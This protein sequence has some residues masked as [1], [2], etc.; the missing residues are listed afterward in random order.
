MARSIQAD[1]IRKHPLMAWVVTQDQ[2]AHSGQFVARLVTN[3]PTVYVMLAGTLAEL[4]D[5]LPPRLER[6]DRHSFHPRE[7]VEIWFVPNR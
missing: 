1:M 7:V 2:D 4:R 3:E 5:Q 6:T